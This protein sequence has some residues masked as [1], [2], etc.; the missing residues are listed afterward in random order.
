MHFK[1]GLIIYQVF[2]LVIFIGLSILSTPQSA[3][4]DDVTVL[5]SAFAPLIETLG[6]EVTVYNWTQSPIPDALLSASAYWSQQ[7]IGCG[8]RC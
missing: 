4:A 8:R 6:R 7:Y 1:S 2:Y 3:M 5:S